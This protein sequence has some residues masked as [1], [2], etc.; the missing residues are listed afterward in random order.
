MCRSIKTLRRADPSES[1]ATPDEIQAAAL[2]FVRKVSG[3]RVP[4]RRNSEAFEAAVA[5]IADSSQ[6][7]LETLAA[8]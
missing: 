1:P 5:E 2:Q 3:Y 4:S 7:L 6:R 8:R